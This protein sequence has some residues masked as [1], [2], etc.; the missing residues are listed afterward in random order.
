[1]QEWVEFG[2]QYAAPSST[3]WVTSVNITD[4]PTGF[5]ITWTDDFGGFSGRGSATVTLASDAFQACTNI[6][7]KSNNFLSTFSES[8]SGNTVTLFSGSF[9]GA[10]ILYEATWSLDCATDQASQSLFDSTQAMFGASCCVST[11]TCCVSRAAVGN[12]KVHGPTH[13]ISWHGMQHKVRKINRCY[14]CSYETH[15]CSTLPF[16]TGCNCAVC[17]NGNCCVRLWDGPSG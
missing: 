9:T 15:E 2:W 14:T 4:V 10:G 8:L 7:R 13:S 3:P 16:P 17:G 6:T 12:G 1:M 11:Y 5:T